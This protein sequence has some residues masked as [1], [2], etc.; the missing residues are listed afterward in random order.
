M[1]PDAEIDYYLVDVFTDQ[2]YG[3][4]QLA[5]LV[6][7]ND[8]LS[9]DEM[10]NIAQEFNFSEVSFIKR[11]INEGEYQVRIYTPEYEVPFAGHPVLG[12][13]Y[14]IA[15]HLSPTPV[16]K[17]TLQVPVGPIHVSLD[18][19]EIV[20]DSLFVME[21]AQPV[22]GPTLTA[23]EV[24]SGLKLDSALI[25]D[26][27]PIQE[28]STG[29]PYL[30]IPLVNL[31][32][33]N[34]LNIEVQT[35]IS[36][37]KEKGMYKTNSPSGLSTSFFFINPESFESF[38]DYNARMFCI[39][40]E[41]LIEDAATGRANGCFLAWLLK[42]QKQEVKALVEQGFQMGRKSYVQLEGVV[43]GDR[44]LLKVGGKVVPVARGKWES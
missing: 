13:S 36:F 16:S 10:Q 27:Y 22:F 9:P 38:S 26:R 33:M 3:G 32:A 31:Q 11:R 21:Q 14:V 43:E 41:A 12:T 28:I 17:L 37:L 2:K 40:N 15:K 8:Q 24:A 18:L 4:N 34:S 1:S 25:D 42:H 6:D 44:Y 23:E 39:E 19:P 30:I 7:F 5:V 29:L 20:D 35:A